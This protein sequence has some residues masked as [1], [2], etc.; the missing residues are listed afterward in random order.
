MEKI[1]LIDHSYH[2]KTKS[3]SFIV[4]LLR[5]YYD[6]E[7]ILDDSWQGKKEPDL[8][9]IDEKYKA[10]IF[11]Q[12]ISP[13]MLSGLKC[14]NVI[15]FPMYDAC[16]DVSIDYWYKI[17][18]VKVICFSKT[19]CDKL[20]M[21]GFQSLY[22]QYF[23]EP[24]FYEKIKEKSIFFWHR[25]AEVTWET[26]KKMIDEQ[27]IDSIHIHRAVDPAQEFV[28]PTK[29]D[30]ILYNIN[31]SDWFDTREE[32]LEAV[33]QKSIYVAP[34][35]TEGIGFSFLEAMAM[36]RAVI[37]ADNPTMNEYIYHGINGYL[38]SEK[39]PKSID[40]SNFEQVQENAYKTVVEG[41]QKWLSEKHKIFDIIKAKSEKNNYLEGKYRYD[42]TFIIMKDKIKMIVKNILP[43]GVVYLAE[44]Y[45]NRKR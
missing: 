3:S 34:R 17:R 5:E 9:F 36:G 1:A 4:D 23:P 11:W 7:I 10:V 30:E 26:V 18:N 8:S 33:K 22:I 44:K 29:V 6:V 13:K 25:R 15:F 24:V 39:D 35:I 32:Y 42:R 43:Y 45:R 2:V 28:S 14:S 20:H 19:L 31:Y 16:C 41:R 27:K 38:F 37:A 40:L 21:L 12:S